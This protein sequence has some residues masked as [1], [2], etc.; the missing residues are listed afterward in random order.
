[1]RSR[2][3]GGDKNHDDAGRV[4]A[5]VSVRERMWRSNVKRLPEEE[6]EACT[7]AQSSNGTDGPASPHGLAPMT[8]PNSSITPVKHPMAQRPNTDHISAKQTSKSPSPR[9]TTYPKPTSNGN[10]K[11]PARPPTRCTC[12]GPMWTGAGLMMSFRAK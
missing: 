7:T 12:L 1:M 8:S 5:I 3:R 11:S 10:T 4:W 6:Q 9:Q 2:R